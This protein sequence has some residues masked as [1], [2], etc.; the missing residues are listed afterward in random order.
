MQAVNLFMLGAI[1]MASA[2]AS[3]YFFR[4]WKNTGDR[5]FFLFGL[6]FLIEGINRAAL[7]LLSNPKEGDPFFY[8]IRMLAF[9][10]ILFAILGKNL[11]RK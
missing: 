8:L 4:F 10:L 6:A 2:I 11:S 7:A 5:L 3:L 1:A 9:S